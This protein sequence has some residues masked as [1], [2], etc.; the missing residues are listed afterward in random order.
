VSGILLQPFVPGTATALLDA[1]S[2]AQGER[3]WAHAEFEASDV[4]EV[5]SVKLF[6]RKR[7]DEA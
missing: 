7:K 1:L 3:T 6:E 5:T 4:G 2:V